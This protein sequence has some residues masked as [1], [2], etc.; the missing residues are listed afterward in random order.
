M[1]NRPTVRCVD[2]WFV[3]D[4]D[5]AYQSEGGTF[6]YGLPMSKTMLGVT[7]TRKQN[8]ALRHRAVI[9]NVLLSCTDTIRCIRLA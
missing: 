5:M 2:T 4:F 9:W 8:D 6:Q 1:V 7:Q 3:T